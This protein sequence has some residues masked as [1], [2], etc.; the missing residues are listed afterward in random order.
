[1]KI[2]K[3]L[4]FLILIVAAGTAA[5]VALLDNDF[6]LEEQLE[7]NAPRELVFE[8]VS[9]LKNW[10]AWSSVPTSTTAASA[11]TELEGQHYLSWKNDSTGVSGE[12]TITQ[13][14]HYSSL[15]QKATLKSTTGTVH[16]LID[17]NFEHE[18]D[19][20]TIAVE[21]KGRLDFW[22]IA[23][24]LFTQDSIKP[25]LALSVNKD[26]SALKALVLKK[27]SAYA[28]D[29]L[30]TGTSKTKTYLYSTFAAKNTP[31]IIRRKREKISQKLDAYITAH[32]IKKKGAPFM[33]FNNIDRRHGNIIASI[34]IPVAS[35]TTITDPD[36]EILVGT[37]TGSTILKSVLKGDY[38]NISE[39]WETTKIYMRNHQL[40]QIPQQP[41]YEV[42]ET[43][44]K[45]TKNPANWVT[46]LYIPVQHQ[47]K[48]A[49]NR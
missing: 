40:T 41:A 49:L 25:Q 14:H 43:T 20:T 5:Y 6:T 42:F 38:K 31:E 1:M 45:D 33:V 9:N 17:W 16:Y 35:H 23:K 37:L 13:T 12:L 46:L 34:G 22:A 39:L 7:L 27:M 19:K 47:E 11:N 3:Y 2:I 21:I 15:Q 24:R 18:N 10:K 4:F 44:K 8:Q 32:H 30:G 29:I 36:S 26:L 48:A 28:I